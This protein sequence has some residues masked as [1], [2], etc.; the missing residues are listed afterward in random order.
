ME[1]KVFSKENGNLEALE[2]GH[3]YLFDKGMIATTEKSRYNTY[4]LPSSLIRKL[5]TD[6]EL[7][8][9]LYPDII[10]GQTGFRSTKLSR[11]KERLGFIAG[12]KSVVGEFHL[13]SE[14]LKESLDL[15][16]SAGATF[17]HVISSL[18]S[19]IYPTSIEIEYDGTNYF[20]ETLKAN[21]DN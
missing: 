17:E 3:I 9:D 2:N 16:S 19:S 10:T 15:Y 21:Y 4:L 8:E 11:I 13:T 12:R 20:W 14:Q 18:T 1:K 7:A 5:K 6:E